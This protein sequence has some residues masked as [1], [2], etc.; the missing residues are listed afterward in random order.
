MGKLS[1][2]RARFDTTSSS[3]PSAAPI[4]PTITPG[5]RLLRPDIAGG[6][7]TEM[8]ELDRKMQEL[9]MS[10]PIGTPKSLPSRTRLIMAG[11]SYA[12]AGLVPR[13]VAL[14][15]AGISPLPTRKQNSSSGQLHTRVEPADGHDPT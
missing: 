10:A 15:A 9:G 5:L 14:K 11:S 1:A 7:D 13:I 8:G 12:E 2:S 3:I 4:R 6:V